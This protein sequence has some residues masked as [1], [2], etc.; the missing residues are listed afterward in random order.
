MLRKLFAN[1]IFTLEELGEQKIEDIVY[2]VFLAS[3][4]SSFILR[5]LAIKDLSSHLLTSAYFGYFC[6]FIIFLK[7]NKSEICVH[8]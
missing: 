5:Y 6:I 4:S 1:Y 3:F 7:Y 2:F 8:K